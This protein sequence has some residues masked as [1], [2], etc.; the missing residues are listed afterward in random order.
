M[1]H[2]ATALPRDEPRGPG[3]AVAPGLDGT[4]FAVKAM[5]KDKD[6]KKVLDGLRAGKEMEKEAHPADTTEFILASAALPF[7]LSSWT[8]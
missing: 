5:P 7:I 1:P 8:A 4:S 6:L 2:P 3:F